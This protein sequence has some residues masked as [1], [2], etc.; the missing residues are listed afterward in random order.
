M[1]AF[2]STA[3]VISAAR[4]FADEKNRV[5]QL[6]GMLDIMSVDANEISLA[7]LSDRLVHLSR[8]QRGTI[9]AID[10]NTGEVAAVLTLD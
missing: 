5:R 3:E 10:D 9:F 7:Y 8:A 6:S 4:T 1:A 2:Y